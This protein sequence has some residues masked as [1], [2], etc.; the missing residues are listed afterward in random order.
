MMRKF[1]ALMV[2]VAV[3][4]IATAAP[5]VAAAPESTFVSH[6][7]G[8]AGSAILTDCVGVPAG[9]TCRAVDVFAFEQRVNEDGEHFGGPGMDITLRRGDRLH[10][11]LEFVPTVVGFGFTEEATVDIARNLSGGSASAADVELF[12]SGSVS[13]NVQWEGTGPISRVRSH[14]MFSNP[15]FFVNERSSNSS[16]LADAS[17]TL[18]G[19]P[20]DDVSL[21][22][23]G[24]Q[25]TR[26]APCS[27]SRP[28]RSP[29]LRQRRPPSATAASPAGRRSSPTV[30]RG[31]PS[32]RCVM[33]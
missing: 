20:V 26:S 16:R 7:S 1:A 11:S 18:D 10:E 3:S 4:G 23:S 33:R 6:F 15:E 17:G 32:A 5:P 8:R 9:E 19:S 24:L 28:R 22:P 21:F 14:G 2:V 30:Q 27:G 25:T 31:R 12:P 13:V 29:S